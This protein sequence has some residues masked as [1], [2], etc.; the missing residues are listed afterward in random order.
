MGFEGKIKKELRNLVNSEVRRG[1]VL[2]AEKLMRAA[3][4]F[5]TEEKQNTMN[6]K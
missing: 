1:E 5:S 3:V 6:Q 4:D 2:T